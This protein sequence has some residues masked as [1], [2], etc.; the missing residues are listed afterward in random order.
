MPIFKLNDPQTTSTPTIDVT[1][2]RGSAL[3]IGPHVFSLVV[4][5][6]SGNT[7]QPMLFT[8]VVKDDK[9]PTAVLTAPPTVPTGQSFTLD[10]SQSSDVGGG[11]V[12]QWQWTQVS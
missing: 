4:T 1:P 9:A 5:D 10:G 6:D 8:V 7:S 3:T 11:K 2:G 12:V